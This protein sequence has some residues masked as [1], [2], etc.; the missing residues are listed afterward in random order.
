MGLKGNLAAVNLADVFQLLSRGKSTGL[1]RVQAPEGTRFIEMQDG[2][3]SLAGRGT[4][5][6]E[7]GDLLL[8]R[9]AIND[10][11]LST[12][13]KIH[14]ENGMVLGQVL[15]EM[16]YVVRADLDEALRF[17]IE[18]EVCDL[19]TLREGDFDF[20]AIA[21]LDTKIAPGGGAVRLRIE[22]DSLLLEAARRADEWHGIEQRITT[23]SLLFRLTDE[24][25]R[26]YQD[27][28]GISDEGRTLM[29]LIQ[30]KHTVEGIVQKSCLGRLN[31][32]RMILELWDAQMIE[33]VPKTEYLAIA[34]AQME[35]G[36][37]AD[38]H[39]IA[40]QASKVGSPETIKL[41][42]NLI[43]TLRKQMATDDK[44][45]IAQLVPEKKNTSSPTI[46]KSANTNLII[47]KDRLP[48]RK[49]GMF[50]API[51]CVAGMAAY[52]F[53]PGPNLD[54]AARLKLDRLRIETFQLVYAKKYLEASDKSKT[55]PTT[56][57]SPEIKTL[58][59]KLKNDTQVEIE[60]QWVRDFGP[61]LRS[62]ASGGEFTK[63]QLSNFSALLKDYTSVVFLSPTIIKDSKKLVKIM[64]DLNARIDDVE[65]QVRL[66]K[67]RRN[68]SGQSSDQ[69]IASYR[70]FLRD[71][72]PEKFAR[73]ARIE[74][75][76][77]LVPLREAER[78]VALARETL[79]KGG[80]DSARKLNEAIR[81]QYAGTK[82]A[83]EAEKNLQDLADRENKAVDAVA[84]IRKL[85]LQRSS[86]E[87]RRIAKQLLDSKPP[88]AIYADAVREMRELEPDI[89]EKD[90]QEKIA[91]ANRMWEIDPKQARAAILE[92]VNAFPYSE[93]ASGATLRVQ[94]TSLP[95][96]A[97][98][99][100]KD[101]VIGKTPMVAALPVMGPLALTFTQPGFEPCEVIEN[102][103]RSERI[104]AVFV[105]KPQMSILTPVAASAGMV[106]FKDLV[107][108]AGGS[109]LA[110]C[111]ARTLEVIRRVNLEGSPQT[112]KVLDKTEQP[113]ALAKNEL[114]LRG[115]SVNEEDAEAFAFVSCSGSYFFQIASNATGDFYRIPCPPGAV[116]EPQMYRPKKA[117]AEKLISVVTKSGISVFSDQRK[118]QKT[119]AFD[120]VGG[121]EQPFG[122]AFDGDTYYV[123]RD[124]NC[125]YAVEGY[126]GE[127]KWK[128][129]CD[130]R[131]SLPPAVTPETK[132]VAVADIK[133]R[134]LFLDTDSYGR[135]KGHSDLGAGSSTGL[136]ATANGFVGALD[137]GTLVLLP[138]AGGAPVWT[139]PMPG[140]VLFTPLV[141]GPDKKDKNSVGTAIVCCELQSNNYVLIAVNLKDGSL[142]WRGR[143]SSKPITGAIGSDAVYIGTSDNELMKFDFTMSGN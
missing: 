63:A 81:I 115:L 138:N 117:A 126:R 44:P 29:R 16:N 6:I 80:F 100:L 36:Q 66:D 3:I 8:S 136:R 45:I 41:A 93:A 22:P 101:Q 60:T 21:S 61:L 119:V 38:A 19:F 139:T 54:Q 95:D 37:I 4:Q 107:L 20:L 35:A 28:D 34:K 59:E 12:A 26:V 53:W 24:G 124:N 70:E 23:Q 49:I 89:P 98:V 15:I 57:V 48:W 64:K 133:G 128:K 1:L 83:A 137:D 134:V 142:L 77:Q 102:N 42:I 78:Q 67:I 105:R 129:Q 122:Y 55:F 91:K 52:I 121:P 73:D 50:A 94:L 14:K 69:Q 108:L 62:G 43:E 103:F 25:M 74:L 86:D 65:F 113:A 10:E 2:H 127:L 123:P 88:A 51:L 32:N 30:A 112:I 7:L 68:S 85:K 130:S 47:K 90:L 75:Y 111:N 79:E 9:K 13:M 17:L 114:E 72:P 18:E 140:K 82:L 143:L 39:R 125:L 104:Q 46:K 71:D 97:Q 5:Y 131:I 109:E 106:A 120:P 99:T 56:N 31:S 40:V 141:R 76:K 92:V 118:I 132:T 58:A 27:A 135:E 84:K 96:G 11:N 110:V 116:G 87:A 33:A